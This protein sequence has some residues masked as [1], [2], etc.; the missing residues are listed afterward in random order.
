MIFALEFSPG[1]RQQGTILTKTPFQDRLIVTSSGSRALDTFL[2]GSSPEEGRK[3]LEAAA[4]T[5]GKI[6][7]DGFRTPGLDASRVMVSQGG[8]TSL[9]TTTD[10]V[11]SSRFKGGCWKDLSGLFATLEAGIFSRAARMRFLKIYLSSSDGN[12]SHRRVKR[13]YRALWRRERGERAKGR[14]PRMI[15]IRKAETPGGRWSWNV[16]FEEVIKSLGLEEAKDFDN[17]PPS[18]GL[19]RD[20]GTR[21]NYRLEHGDN[22]FY[23]KVHREGNIA[24]DRSFGIK[25]WN[26]HLRLMRAGLAVPEPVAWGRGKGFSFFMSEACGTVTAEEFAGERNSTNLDARRA[27][28]RELGY[29]VRR[30][31]G[32][33]F[34][35]RDLYLCHV[36]MKKGGPLLIDLQRLTDGSLFK[37]HR[38]IKDLAALLYSSLD[39]P[40]S[41]SDCMRFFRTYWGRKCR[42]GG[43]KKMIRAVQAKAARIRARQIAKEPR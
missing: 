28:A 18:Q 43:A 2:R 35:H 16:R 37:G 32:F 33:G 42:D 39:L 6:H 38:K 30:M 22:A 7:G 1:P 19:L 34:F 3:A 29:M 5:L 36:I 40:V 14:F 25:E 23:L 26:N 12:A 17:L 41:R 10:S 11:K 13:L 9:N 21:R 15:R 27:L 24:A 31:H 8:E 4:R 20:L